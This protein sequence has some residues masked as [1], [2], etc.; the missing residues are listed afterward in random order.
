MAGYPQYGE[1]GADT[2]AHLVTPPSQQVTYG[3]STTY[4]RQLLWPQSAV[5]TPQT[6]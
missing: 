3:Q 2:N 4:R 6:E 1:C 5:Q